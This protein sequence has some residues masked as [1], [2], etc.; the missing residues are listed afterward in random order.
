MGACAY[1]FKMLYRGEVLWPSDVVFASAAGSMMK[2]FNIAL[3]GDMKKAFAALVVFV[4]VSA[5]F[6]L[7]IF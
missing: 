2:D 1:Y 7:P 5:F 4:A 6:T 3:T